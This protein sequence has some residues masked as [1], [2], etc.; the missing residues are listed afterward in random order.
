[1]HPGFFTVKFHHQQKYHRGRK[2]RQGEEPLVICA[3]QPAAAVRTPDEKIHAAGEEVAGS[4][5]H[6][7]KGRK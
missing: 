2:H 3:F 4:D 7:E 1:M 5:R 6:H